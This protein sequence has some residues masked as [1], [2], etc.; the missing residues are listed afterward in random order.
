MPRGHRAAPSRGASGPLSRPPLRCRSAQSSCAPL[1]AL[2][3][4]LAFLCAL[5]AGLRPSAPFGP[6][7]GGPSV[8]ARARPRRAGIAPPAL[9]AL[10]LA[11]GPGRMAYGPRPASARCSLLGPGSQR[12]GRSG[13]VLR[14]GSA[15]GRL[16]PSGRGPPLLGQA[17]APRFAPP[18]GAWSRLRRSLGAVPAPPGKGK[19]KKIKCQWGLLSR[20]PSPP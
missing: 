16:R 3:G 13:R 15:S 18:G 11:Y 4:L 1:L 12:P 5:R 7:T 8:A 14:S 19:G 6:P 20:S 2:S 9:R 17:R 10:A